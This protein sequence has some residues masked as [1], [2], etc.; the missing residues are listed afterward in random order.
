MGP[1]KDRKADCDAAGLG[2]CG[3]HV[4]KLPHQGTAGAEL[5]GYEQ[6]ENP[7]DR[8]REFT[9]MVHARITTCARIGE[10]LPEVN[11]GYFAYFRTVGTHE[12]DMPCASR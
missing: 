11:P 7:Q 2:I 5:L 4:L 6:K 12:F 3:F 10:Q 8:I 1:G 9:N